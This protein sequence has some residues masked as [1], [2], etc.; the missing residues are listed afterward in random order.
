MTLRIKLLLSALALTVGPIA[1]GVATGTMPTAAE[2]GVEAVLGA[3]GTA[4]A[5]IGD[6]HV[7]ASGSQGADAVCY[8]VT[9]G[10]NQY[11]VAKESCRDAFSGS[12]RTRSGPKASVLNTSHVYCSWTETRIAYWY[13][14]TS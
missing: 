1:A 2:S 9:P 11:V 6:C 12:I 13:V 3:E 10:G 14:T 7:S 8:S 5:S 4:H